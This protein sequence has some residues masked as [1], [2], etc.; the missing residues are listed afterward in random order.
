MAMFPRATVGA[1]DLT[2]V[3]AFHDSVPGAMGYTRTGDPGDNGSSW[4]KD[5]SVEFSVAKP[6]NRQPACFANGGAIGFSAPNRAAV[7]AFHAAALA[8]GDM[9]EGA[10][11]ARSWAPNAFARHVRDLDGDK[12]A[13]CSF[14]AERGPASQSCD[15]VGRPPRC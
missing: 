4:G 15:C 5:G 6:A 1:N 8:H 11:G 3:R 13:A 2:K 14:A 7:A 9:D 12:P 10:V